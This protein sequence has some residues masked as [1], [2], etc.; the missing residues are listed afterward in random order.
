MGFV[1]NL[2]ETIVADWAGG[3]GNWVTRQSVQNASTWC[4]GPS[5]WDKMGSHGLFPP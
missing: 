4:A 2:K 5:T 3:G 1:D